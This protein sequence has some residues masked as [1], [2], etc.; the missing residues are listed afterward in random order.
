MKTRILIKQKGKRG[1]T[2]TEVMI[3]SF[4]FIMILG[5]I[6][7][8]YISGSEVYENSK[9][10][11]DLQAQAR[12]A[13]NSISAELA[14][15]T[16]TTPSVGQSPPNI[17]I[18]PA[19][20]NNNMTFYLPTYVLDPVTQK[21]RVSINSSGTIQWDNNTPINYQYNS[22]QH[23]LVRVANG[24]QTILA[25]DVSSV[26]FNNVSNYEVGTTL[27][28]NKSTPRGR[29]ISITLSSIVRLRN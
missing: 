5:T 13:L 4:I 21:L 6:L 11:A 27:T 26:Q 19:P 20:G 3:A 25:H 14:N 24:A 16:K 10:Q 9:L 29:N 1:F 23:T 28:L 18:P 2:L 17:S 7:N 8:I 22:N 12:L 15:A